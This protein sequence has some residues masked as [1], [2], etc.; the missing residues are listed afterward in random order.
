VLDGG[1][2]AVDPWFA[3]NERAVQ[4]LTALLNEVRRTDS[5]DVSNLSVALRQLR[6][7]ALTSRRET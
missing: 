7:V 6:N 2:G 3:A 5:F 1:G 4:R